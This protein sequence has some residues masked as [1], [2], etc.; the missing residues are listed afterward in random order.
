MAQLAAYGVAM[1]AREFADRPAA[2]RVSELR[3]VDRAIAAARPG[4]RMLAL[5]AR[6]T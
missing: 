1:T 4:S 6:R 3:R 2:Q 5:G